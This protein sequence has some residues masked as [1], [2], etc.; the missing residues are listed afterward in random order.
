MK[1]WK[2]FL[3]L[4]LMASFLA[5]CNN[6]KS[7][8]TSQRHNSNFDRIL[9]EKKIVAITDYNSTDYFIYKGQPM[10]FHYELLKAYA[11]YLNV[12]LE[13]QINE[14]L[15][16]SFKKL[17]N[18]EVDLLAMSLTVTNE[19]KKNIDFTQAI[20][21]TKQVLVQRRP[22]DWWKMYKHDLEELLIRNQ[23]DLAQKTITVESG[24]TFCKRLENLSDE[25][26]ESIHIDCIEDI[27]TEQLI[28]MVSHYKIQ[29][30][31]AD[32]I[33]AK[34]NQKYYPNIDIKTAVSFPQ[35]I[36]WAL[37]KNADDLKS[38]LNKW[39]DEFQ[40]TMEYRV[41][42]ARYFESSGSK[43]RQKSD[44][45]SITGGKI[46]KFDAPIQAAARK[47]GWDWRLL[48]SLIYEES[49]FDPTAESWAGAQGI[50]QM[51]PET[52]A[53]YNVTPDS[54]V[55]EQIMAG[56]LYLKW[57]DKY[58]PKTVTDSV[59]RVEFTLAAYNIGIGH[60]I[61]ACALAKKHGK[62]PNI[63]K[64]NVDYFILHKSDPKYF[65]DPVVKNGYARGIQTYTYVKNI[66]ERYYHYQLLIKESNKKPA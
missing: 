21:Q 63:W 52:A 42:Y 64:D 48:A 37:P 3:L 28:E 26:G 60:V 6:N 55:D 18:K 59:S 61:D 47:I 20:L 43:N 29:Y 33:V 62:N 40:K 1:F 31:V 45:F 38:G 34:V 7:Q 54:P 11:K 49:Q 53:K 17:K 30:T 44:Y 5:S 8:N 14:N 51:L 56:A 4:H 16:S 57:I 24:S 36:A 32:E 65:K 10:G 23:I 13:L 50:M 35:Q 66:M 22:D 12:E 9:T 46:S 27:E 41:I 39:L 19:R 15:E 2:F 25:I 58:L